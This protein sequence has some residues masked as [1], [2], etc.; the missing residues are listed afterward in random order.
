L[1]TNKKRIRLSCNRSAHVLGWLRA[2]I[3]VSIICVWVHVRDSKLLCVLPH[4]KLLV[5][6]PCEWW[7]YCLCA[8]VCSCHVLSVPCFCSGWLCARFLPRATCVF[9]SVCVCASMSFF[10]THSVNYILKT[11]G[12][13]ETRRAARCSV[14]APL[15][16]CEEMRRDAMQICR[17][18]C[19]HRLH[20]LHRPQ[21]RLLHHQPIFVPDHWFS[22]T[23][24]NI[25]HS[26]LHIFAQ[27]FLVLE[28]NHL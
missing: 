11:V 17:L 27:F 24:T 5:L 8:P 14:W 1:H 7:N 3:H 21:S 22:K 10:Y 23:D 18:H 6:V 15:G 20:R 25:S 19:L 9:V 26:N 2:W 4:F 12:E 16:W 28:M 13:M